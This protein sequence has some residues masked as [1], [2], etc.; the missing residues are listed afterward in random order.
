[1]ADVELRARVPDQ[2]GERR[3]TW[4][5]QHRLPVRGTTRL[6][7]VGA[8]DTIG[9]ADLDASD[10]SVRWQRLLER[11]QQCVR[12]AVQRTVGRAGDEQPGRFAEWCGQCRRRRR[13]Q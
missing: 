4:H 2:P 8:G 1:V 12:P 11:R 9:A 5:Q 3:L 7:L 10:R 13:A 6:E